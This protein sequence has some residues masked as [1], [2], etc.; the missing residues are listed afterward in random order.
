MRNHILFTREVRYHRTDS[1]KFHPPLLDLVIFNLG[2]FTV[3]EL[4]GCRTLVSY[5]IKV[6]PSKEVIPF[7]Y[8]FYYGHGLLFCDMIVQFTSL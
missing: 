1:C 5:E 8:F 4:E 2:A 7:M 6:P 3:V